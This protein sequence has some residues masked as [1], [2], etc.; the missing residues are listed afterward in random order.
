MNSNLHFNSVIPTLLFQY[1][2]G[3]LIIDTIIAMGVTAL[4]SYLIN[5]SFLLNNL[6]LFFKNKLFN[7]KTSVKYIARL[8][9]SNGYGNNH[10]I[11]ENFYAVAFWII[12]NLEQNNFINVKKLK[13]IQLPKDHKKSN[14]LSPFTGF[15][16]LLDQSDNNIKYKDKDIYISY[17]LTNNS[18]KPNDPLGE[19][20]L[21]EYQQ[22]EIIISSNKLN[23]KELLTFIEENPI[24]IYNEYKKNIEK[25]TLYYLTFKKQDEDNYSIYDSYKWITTK[26]FHHIISEHTNLIK[27]LLNNFINNKLEYNKQ[28]KAYK[29]T[30]LLHG[31]PGC[32]K[33]SMIKAVANYTKRHII[34]IAFPRI[35]SREA[36][37]D[38][39]HNDR[40]NNIKIPQN[41]AIYVFD[42][43]DKMGKL[44]Q[45]NSD[46]EDNSDNEI[47]LE[48]NDNNNINTY[49]LKSII[50]NLKNDNSPNNDDIITYMKNKIKNDDPPLMLYDIL[51]IMDGAL[52]LNGAITFIIVNNVD[53]LH[54]AFKR[55]GRIDHILE[56]GKATI[57]SLKKIICN[58]YENIN[59]NDLNFLNNSKYNKKWSP[60]EIE[61]FCTMNFKD[62]IE[63][64]K[65]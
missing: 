43:M 54:K 25:N 5:N 13:E 60:A 3:N 42:E 28:G 11:T 21:K 24:K 17:I 2:T 55:P 44:I 50:S 58:N 57:T 19:P 56:F 22:H 47:T 38:I 16:Y 39:F 46:N 61:G 15:L 35:K 51:N 12:K 32:G 10:Q 18:I 65:K 20:V 14:I 40:K 23:I 30:F 31:P 8:Y 1:R 4:I 53:K 59:M 63:F 6:F 37:T 33:T 29:I 45:N 41:K 64:L 48:K 34:D 9:L 26:Q 7:S 49:N 27:N 52:E 36:L 62:L